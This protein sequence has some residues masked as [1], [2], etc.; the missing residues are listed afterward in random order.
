M[1]LCMVSRHHARPCSAWCESGL[2]SSQHRTRGHIKWF[3][4]LG[5]T[6]SSKC[7]L[8][9]AHAHSLSYQALQN[10]PTS[11]LAFPLHLSNI[12]EHTCPYAGAAVKSQGPCV[13]AHQI[14]WGGFSLGAFGVCGLICFVFLALGIKLRV[15]CVQNKVLPPA[16]SAAHLGRVLSAG[17]TD[18][19]PRD[20][21]WLIWSGVSNLML[22]ES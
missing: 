21:T 20:L 5:I 17:L 16:P 1:K 14:T 4:A 7:Q 22:P 19:A 3:Q 18:L 13:H 10:N 12:E 6:G 8:P 9:P 11:C 15:F 2:W